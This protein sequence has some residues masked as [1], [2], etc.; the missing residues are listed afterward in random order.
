[1]TIPL[2]VPDVN[3][4]L[5]LISP[6]HVHYQAAHAWFSDTTQWATTPYTEAGLV[7]LVLN[8]VVVG[9]TFTAA[10]V[11]EVLRGLRALPLH[12]FLA[13]DSSLAAP[14][15]DVAALVGHRQVT[16]Y[17]L[18]NLVARKGAQLA[19]FD[20]RLVASLAPEDRRHVTIIPA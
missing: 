18:V 2:A 11:L 5:A 14:H 15:I 12:R 3:V 20:S 16:D 1:M 6:D 8:P 13:D 7:R 10:T 19:T 17:H 4:L 9:A